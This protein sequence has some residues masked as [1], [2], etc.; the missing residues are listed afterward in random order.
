MWPASYAALASLQIVELEAAVQHQQRAGTVLRDRQF[1]GGNQGVKH[2]MKV[3][4]GGHE[5]VPVY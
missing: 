2:H 4:A 5:G 1:V 3:Q